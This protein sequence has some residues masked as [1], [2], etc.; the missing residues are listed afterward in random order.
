MS[1]VSFG[2]G[3]ALIAVDCQND[4]A[5]PTGTLYVSGGEAVVE[6]VSGA[7]QRALEAGAAVFYT[8]DWHPE[9]TPHFAKDG[10]IWPVHCV[11]GTRGAEFHADLIVN[12]PVIRKGTHGEDGYSGFTVRDP[13]SGE[14]TSTELEGMLREAGVHRV[15][16]AG[17]A[18]DY[19]VKATAM[20]ALALGFEAQVP[21]EWT[22]PVNLNPNDGDA[23][24]AQLRAAGVDVL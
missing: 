17:L 10:G 12:G 18:L 11:G 7:V 2:P 3:T 6:A 23:A 16:V 4:F 19:C 21:S 13:V 9:D 8:Q 15:V 5:E 1:P 24:V 14:E 20:D 22:A